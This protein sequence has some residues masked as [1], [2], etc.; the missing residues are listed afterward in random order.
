LSRPDP[1]KGAETGAATYRRS[2]IR[3]D[4]DFKDSKI[5]HRWTD[6]ASRGLAVE[7]LEFGADCGIADLPER[8]SRIRISMTVPE[9]RS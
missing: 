1:Q 7:D 8:V 9:H 6:F 2:K 3:E 5:R 4:R